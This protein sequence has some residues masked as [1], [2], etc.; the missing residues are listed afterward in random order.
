MKSQHNDSTVVK[1]NQLCNIKLQHND[2]TV[3][4]LNQLCNMKLQCND[5]S[6]IKPAVQHE[7]TTQWL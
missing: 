6:K 3:V 5:C 4:K 2:S 1:L 7:V